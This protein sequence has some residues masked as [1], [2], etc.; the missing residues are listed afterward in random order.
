MRSLQTQLSTG[1]IT[2]LVALI[3]ILLA[4]STYSL[5]RLAEEFVVTRLEHDMDALL[6]A[7]DFDKAGSPV[8]RPGRLNPIFFQPYSG[9]YY[10]IRVGSYERRS[11]SLWDADLA[12]PPSAAE[13]ASWQFAQG[14]QDQKL[15]VLARTFRIQNRDVVIAVSEDF[16]PLEKGLQHIIIGCLVV[17]IL[18]LAGLMLLQRMIVRRGLKPLDDTRRDILRL[19]QGEIRQL[20]TDIPLEVQPLVAEIN[21]LVYIMTQR[22]QRSRRAVGNLAHALKTPLTILL[23]LS[24]HPKVK[25]QDALC[26]ELGQQPRRIRLL[27]DRELK[28]ARIAGAAA[29]GQRVILENEIKDLIDTL[30]K[31]YRDKA[32]SI[33]YQIPTGSF[34]SG[35]RDDLLE[36]LG[37]LLDNACQWAVHQ[38]RLTVTDNAEGLGLRVEDDGPGCPP[39]QLD[40]LTQRGVRIDESH[41]GHGLGLAIVADILEHYEGRLHLGCSS[42]LGGFLAEVE[43]P[44]LATGYERKAG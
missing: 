25:H 34:F 26:G 5:H 32:L 2:A 15:L 39:E 27:I 40:L 12:I 11:R 16:T 20:D 44:S 29:P 18:L 38:V 14:P 7:L 10:K 31:I 17:A 33:Q 37:N 13:V 3:G 9:H 1:L 30:K 36:V 24:E 43:I 19:A 41:G 21:R 42:E 22:L 8:L 4:I 35:D 6:V 28:R 23:Q